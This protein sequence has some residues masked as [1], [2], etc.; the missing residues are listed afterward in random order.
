MNN[1]QHTLQE[2][3]SKFPEFNAEMMEQMFQ[4]IR[5]VLEAMSAPQRAMAKMLLNYGRV[6]VREA[7]DTPDKNLRE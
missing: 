4:H 7:L 6:A 1:L 3:H 2:F 5:E